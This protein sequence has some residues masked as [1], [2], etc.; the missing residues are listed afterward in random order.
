MM[1]KNII[2][3]AV[4]TV[5]MT[6]VSTGQEISLQKSKLT[7]GLATFENVKTGSKE[8]IK[9]IM[10]PSVKL[11]DEPTFVK[12]NDFDFENGTIEVDV[13]SKFLP[14]APDW[15]RGFIGLAFRIN[16]DNS[17]FESIYIRPDN[18]RSE[19]QIRRN[20]SVQYF[21]YPDF[22]FDLLRKEAPE[23]YESYAD[24]KMDSWIKM[25]IVVKGSEAR[26][27]LNNNEQPSI[28][29]LDMKHGAKNNG[30]I[31]LWVGPGTE[32]YFKNLKVLKQ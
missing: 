22:K 11:F 13:L 17:K 27:Y 15:A 24:M 16:Q 7:A 9:V 31:G 20:H 4:F 32:G 10:D 3:S 1:K 6:A 5:F 23:K 21:A 8:T 28:V 18:G 26:L 14:D 19:D 25:K 2:L 30:S 12:L 29:V